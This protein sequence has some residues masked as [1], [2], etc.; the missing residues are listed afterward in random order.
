MFD[1]GWEETGAG[2]NV[3][4]Q[5]QEGQVTAQD[6]E[7]LEPSR[8]RGSRELRAGKTRSLSVSEKAGSNVCFGRAVVV[9]V[10][11]QGQPEGHRELQ[12]L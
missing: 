2:E 4:V 9:G 5:L 6:V 12:M 11:D 1:F 3:C 8:T 7:A 10:V